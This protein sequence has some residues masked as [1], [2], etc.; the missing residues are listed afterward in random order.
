MADATLPVISHPEF[1]QVF[2]Q[3]IEQEVHRVERF[4]P[5]FGLLLLP[6]QIVRLRNRKV[7]SAIGYLYK[8]YISAQELGL[9]DLAEY[10]RAGHA[11]LMN[12]WARAARTDGTAQ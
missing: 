9:T 6:D 5:R 7:S 1:P 2:T 3:A 8:S 10:Y 4:Y 12:E 11:L